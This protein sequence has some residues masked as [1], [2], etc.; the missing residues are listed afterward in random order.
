M[1]DD[2]FCMVISIGPQ[3]SESSKY[4][5]GVHEEI[6]KECAVNHIV[7]Y[8]TVRYR[9]DQEISRYADD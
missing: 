8:S 6:S 3:K 1:K 2:L 4:R 9:S 5:H 7:Q